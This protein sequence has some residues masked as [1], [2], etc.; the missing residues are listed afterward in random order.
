MSY[1]FIK[2]CEKYENTV[3][4]ILLGPPPSN[5]VC[6]KMMDEIL[7][8]LKKEEE[9]K[10]KKLIIFKGEGDHF[11]FGASVEEHMPDKVSDMLPKFHNFVGKVLSLS[12]PTLANVSGFCLG[13]GF[14]LAL[15]CTFL[16]AEEDS[17]FAVPE[18]KLGVFPPVA[19]VLLPLRSG[20]T[21]SSKVILSGETYDA[22]TLYEKGII[23][24]ISEKGKLDSCV[25]EFVEKTILKKSASSLRI[26]QKAAR[27]VVID[28][29]NKYIEQLEKL[30]L[31]DLMET[32]DAKEGILSFIEKR[33]PKWS[34]S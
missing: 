23:N 11:S 9:K 10:H 18:I 26:T 22:K 16:F 25:L 13:G 33:K 3:T 28:Q 5:I 2:V 29:Y 12:I 17:K 1:E 34:D 4:E 6:S 20:D 31:K 19:C 24:K 27:M 7:D 30:Y 15:A 32:K 8:C 21:F 14:E